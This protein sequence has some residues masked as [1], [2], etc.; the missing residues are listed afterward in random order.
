M[1]DTEDWRKACNNILEAVNKL[2]YHWLTQDMF[3]FAYVIHPKYNKSY[4]PGV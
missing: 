4:L 2:K 3:N 1:I